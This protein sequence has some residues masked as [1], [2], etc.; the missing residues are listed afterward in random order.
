MP[1][2]NTA[3]LEP[4]VAG[5][6]D[7]GDTVALA[8]GAFDVLHVGQVR[9]LKNARRQADRLVVAV[10]DDATVEAREGAGRPIL[11]AADRAELV[12]A[13]EGV[14][15]VVICSE[16]TAADLRESIDADVL[17]ED[18]EPIEQSTRELIARIA[19]QP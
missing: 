7:H 8:N 14:D 10:S 13:L 17:C 12:A 3:E 5:W 6:R 19:D 11:S 2:V 18:T 16:A 15:A 1:I 4:L 9:Y